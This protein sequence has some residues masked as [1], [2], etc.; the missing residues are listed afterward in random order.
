MELKLTANIHSPETV[1]SIVRSIYRQHGRS[2]VRLGH[3]SVS[4]QDYHFGPYLVVDLSP[5]V[6]HFLYVIL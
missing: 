3:S 2:G 4:L 6:Q 5:L 1:E